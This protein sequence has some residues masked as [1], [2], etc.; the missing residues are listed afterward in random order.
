M[1]GHGVGPEFEE[2]ARQIV[3]VVGNTHEGGLGR[4]PGSLMIVPDA[5]VTDGLTK[6]NGSFV[7]LRWVV[8]TQERPAAAYE[9][10]HR[11]TAPGQRRVSR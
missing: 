9:P 7:P 10:D 2:P 3:G 8:R 11:A 5:Q 6:L 1:I 4:D